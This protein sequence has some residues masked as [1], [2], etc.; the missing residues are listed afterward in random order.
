MLLVPP[1]SSLGKLCPATR[2]VLLLL[3]CVW[4]LAFAHPWTALLPFLTALGGI[5]LARGWALLRRLLPLLVLLMVMT[6]LIWTL[7]S[8]HGRMLAHLGSVRITGDGI[9]YALAMALRLSGMMMAGI[10][11]I[12]ATSVEELRMG[13]HQ[14]GVPYPV[15][16]AIG[17]AFRLQPVI[18]TML[19]TTI[20][21]QQDP[22]A[23]AQ[24]RRAGAAHAQLR[25]A[26]HSGHSALPAQFR[27]PGHGHRR[28][29]LRASGTAHQ[30][31]RPPVAP[32]RHPCHRRRASR[33]AGDAALPAMVGIVSEIDS[34][35]GGCPVTGVGSR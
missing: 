28:T 21:A 7:L 1:T 34:G 17:L 5:A 32:V 25:P 13:L 15:A 14:L 19:Q 11:F 30:C 10:A 12:A 24:R 16:F 27:S 8:P 33:A 20:E 31:P 9:T 23:S 35:F 3:V 22:R 29:G 18:S 4:M 6:A 26:H 2:I